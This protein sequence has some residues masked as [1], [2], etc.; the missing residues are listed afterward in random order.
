L[1]TPSV[2]NDPLRQLLISH[3]CIACDLSGVVLTRAN[4]EDAD[5]TN[6]NLAGANLRQA[7]LPAPS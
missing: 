4:L 1:A 7:R 3:V 2:A 6:A 5:L